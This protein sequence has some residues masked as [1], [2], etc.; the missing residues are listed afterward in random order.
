MIMK[1]RP[2]MF[3][4]ALCAFTVTV[5]AS[6]VEEAIQ[7]GLSAYKS[8]DFSTAVSQL[9]YAATLIR[10]EKAGKITAVFPSAL[11]GWEAEEAE[12]NSAGGM[13]MGGGITA[14]RLIAKGRRAFLFN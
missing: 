14:N 5:Q 6:E 11:A 2:L 10:Q 13:M 8:G 1:S 7:Q 12:S 3:F 9:D 4:F